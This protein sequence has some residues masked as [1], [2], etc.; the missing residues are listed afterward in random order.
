MPGFVKPLRC[1]KYLLV[2][3]ETEEFRRFTSS[4]NL[5]LE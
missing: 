1:D 4:P 5:K 3:L 2:F